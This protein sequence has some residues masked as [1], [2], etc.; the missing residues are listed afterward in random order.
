MRHATRIWIIVACLLL[1]ATAMANSP[2]DYIPLPPGS[3]FLAAYY[4][5]N[6]ATDYYAKG[7]YISGSTRFYSNVAIGRAV[8]YTQLGPFTIDPQ[9]IVP[10]GQAAVNNKETAG[11]G[12]ANIAAT[13]WFVNDMENKWIVGY[14]PFLIVPIGAYDRK[15]LSMGANRW[16]T[17][18][19]LCVAKGFGDR[20]WLELTGN[21]TFFTDNPDANDGTGRSTTS[22]KL[23]V[24]GFETHL[25]VDIIK[26]MFV[27][28]DYY[29]T[30]GGETSLHGQWQKD[31]L[32]THAI[33]VTAA[34]ML[35]P[36]VQLMAHFTTD[37]S[38]YNGLRQNEVGMRLGFI[39]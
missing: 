6:W 35:S 11:F 24:L 22:S 13:I 31:W 15:G 16:A 10:V 39:F 21:A 17:K 12:D 30:Y 7:K 4:N 19:E 2:R 38:V 1:P 3:F 18:Q 28:A 20:V 26:G 27:S 29:Y 37:V 25:S 23:P 33:G 32:D 9:V 5:H 34:Y 14:T 36:N 8:Y